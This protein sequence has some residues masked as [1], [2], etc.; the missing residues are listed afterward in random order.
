MTTVVQQSC[1]A[2]GTI[3]G[4]SIGCVS[5]VQVT[6]VNTVGGGGQAA[7]VPIVVTVPVTEAQPTQTLFAPC[8]SGETTSSPLQTSAQSSTNTP[9]T[10][11]VLVEITPPPSTVVAA[12]STTLANGS[13]VQTVVTMVT[14]LPPSSVYVA[15]TSLAS[16]TLQSDSSQGSGTNVA[17]IVGGVLG[18]FL[19]LV[20]VVGSLWWFW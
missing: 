7:Q 4:S 15:T 16:P 2:S 3:S 14:T 17:P 6:Q 8:P 1:V 13:V 12:S 11:S 10:T 9:V 18:G 19:G 5:T 20:A